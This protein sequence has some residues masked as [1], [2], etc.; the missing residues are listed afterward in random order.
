MLART[1]V[2]PL[3]LLISLL[4]VAAADGKPRCRLVR[5]SLVSTVVTGADCPSPLG[6]CSRGRLTGD[7][8]DSFFFTLKTMTPTDSTPDTGIMQYTGEMVV[9]TR[10]GPVVL[11]EVGAFDADPEGTGDVAAVSTIVDGGTG[12]VRIEGTFT[13]AGGGNS[14]YVGQV[15]TD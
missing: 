3:T 6:L 11:A 4:P 14:R 15:C 1:R 8:R 9:A 5:G 12:R 13:M 2:L 10:S 7:L